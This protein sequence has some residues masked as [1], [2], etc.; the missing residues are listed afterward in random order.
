MGLG[1]FL[2]SFLIGLAVASVVGPMSVLCIQ[3]TLARG[4]RYGLV[5]GF[6]IATADALYSSLAA[7]GLTVVAGFLVQQQTWVRGIGGIFL[8]YLGLRTAFT[9]PAVRAAAIQTEARYAGAYFSTLAL[10]LT[11][12]LTILSFAA[13]FAGIGIGGGKGGGVAASFV[14]VGVFLGSATWWL[15]LTSGV[16]LVRTRFSPT[17]L[18]WINRVAGVVITLFGVAALISLHR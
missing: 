1:I 4:W 7:F 17:W 10:T 11:N 2:R 13:I 16:A 18:V 14:V 8:I 5:S 9:P 12:P 15:L 3:R 6:G